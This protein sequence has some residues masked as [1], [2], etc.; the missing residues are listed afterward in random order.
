MWS[1]AFA[2]HC[3]RGV[4]PSDRVGLVGCSCAWHCRD[5]GAIC[6]SLGLTSQKVNSF[7]P[8]LADCLPNTE[9]LIRRIV[10]RAW[11]SSLTPILYVE[12][13]R[14]ETP[15]QVHPGG[16]GWWR[17]V[18]RCLGLLTRVLSAMWLG[19]TGVSA[20]SSGRRRLVRCWGRLAFRTWRVFGTISEEWSQLRIFCFGI[21]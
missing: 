13:T 8:S 1:I 4:P 17:G 7:V 11:A 5:E 15:M 10:K 3:E 16:G 18:R 20:S 9:F 12:C 21:D 2:A 14:Y 19:M 6:I